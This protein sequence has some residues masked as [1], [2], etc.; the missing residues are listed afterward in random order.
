MGILFIFVILLLFICIH[1]KIK[2]L[3]FNGFSPLLQD[4]TVV[5]RGCYSYAICVLLGL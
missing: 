5:P 4:K 2:F 3:N 1:F